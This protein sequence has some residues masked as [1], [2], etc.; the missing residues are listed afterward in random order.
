M[1]VKI[2][3]VDTLSSVFKNEGPLILYRGALAAGTGSIVFR[4][5][6]FSVFELFYTKW[7]SNAML[8]THIP[9]SG[10]IEWRTLAAGWMSGSF[11]AMLECPF[12]YA[13]VNR[14]VGQ[15]WK[16]AEV[17]KGFTSVYP[18]G[19]GIMAGYFM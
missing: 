19:V 8:R 13:K 7:E 9:L 2:G 1:G 4:S 14:Q 16:I 10:G 6:G 12:E 11:R 3:Y 5:T 15:S 18:R 17:Y